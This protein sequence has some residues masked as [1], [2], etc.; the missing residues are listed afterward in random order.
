MLRPICTCVI[1]DDRCGPNKEKTMELAE[2]VG[3]GLTVVLI[4]LVAGLI[5]YLADRKSQPRC[6]AC[7]GWGMASVP[8]GRMCF[9]CNG[10]GVVHNRALAG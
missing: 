1:F 6:D 8:D 5:A 2:I 7:N 3:F 9:H 10:K 4:V